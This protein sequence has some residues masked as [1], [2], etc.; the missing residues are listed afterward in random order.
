MTAAMRKIG[1]LLPAITRQPL[2]GPSVSAGHV[3]S[4]PGVTRGYSRGSGDNQVR[5]EVA[6]ISKRGHPRID[7]FRL[8]Q[9]GKCPH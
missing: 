7:G 8:F 2:D 9:R 5:T 1:S 3:G 6:S 4:S